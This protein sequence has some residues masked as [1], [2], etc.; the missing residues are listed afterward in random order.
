MFPI[1]K[2][3]ALAQGLVLLE[4]PGLVLLQEGVI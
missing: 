2:L 1:S 4:A 3:Q